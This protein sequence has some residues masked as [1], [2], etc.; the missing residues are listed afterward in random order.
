MNHAQKGLYF[1]RWM[2]NL[3]KDTGKRKVQHNILLKDTKRKVRAQIDITYGLFKKYV[4]C[5]YRQKGDYVRFDEITCFAGKLELFGIRSSRGI[6]VTNTNYEQRAKV[7]AKQKGI[8][9][10]YEKDLLHLHYKRTPWLS[11][12]KEK[13]KTLD[14]IIFQK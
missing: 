9:L 14:Q 13:R 8:V 12:R 5:K 1:E 2:V 10:L 7:Y 4:E 6:F 11:R 3:Y